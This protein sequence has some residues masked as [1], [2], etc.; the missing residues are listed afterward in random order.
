MSDFLVVGGGI[1]GLMTATTLRRTGASVTLLCGSEP[2]ASDGSLVWLNVSSANDPG[3]AALRATSMRMWQALAVEDGAPIGAK[4][5]LMWDATLDVAAE[6][7]R[8]TALGW[9]ARAIGQ[10]GIAE[11]A[12]GLADPPAT[13]L[14]LPAE[15]ACDPD[16]IMAWA[17]SRASGLTMVAAQATGLLKTDGRVAGVALADGGTVAAGHTVVAAGCGAVGLCRSIGVGVPLKPAPG[18]LFRT[19]PVRAVVSPVI[20]SPDL[21][22]W[23][24]DAGRLIV[25]TSWDRTLDRAAGAEAAAA[26]EMLR[27]MMPA[28]GMPDIETCVTRERPVPVDGFPFV[29][30]IAPGA[31]L[32][33]THSG[34]TLAP[35]IAE[36]LSAELTGRPPPHDLE[37]FRPARICAGIT[38]EA[39]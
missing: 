17:E 7:A 37:R 14:H 13:A 18:L 35:V 5:A 25:A 19:T 9:P 21:D 22:F 29:G 39:G 26:L 33:V 36:T 27:E 4:G 10:D 30:R 12:P 32:A 8:L 1:I 15:T 20:A 11:L 2:R 38:G 31:S 24:D 28:I 34:M 16:D 3:Y 23:Q 6:V